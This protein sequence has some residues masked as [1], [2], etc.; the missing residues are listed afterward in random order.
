MCMY[1][2]VSMHFLDL[3]PP[4]GFFVMQNPLQGTSLTPNEARQREEEEEQGP[5]QWRRKQTIIR[6]S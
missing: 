1:V 2:S 6:A 5:S 3:P 4:S